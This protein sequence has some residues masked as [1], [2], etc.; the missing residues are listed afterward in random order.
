MRKAPGLPGD[1]GVQPGR[2]HRATVVRAWRR[3]HQGRGHL[4]RR[5]ARTL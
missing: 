5:Q 4:R 3:V 1:D 2:P